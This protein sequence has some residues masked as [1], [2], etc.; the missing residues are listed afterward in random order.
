MS[1]IVLC[2]LLTHVA[3]ALQ[4]PDLPK[5]AP[6]CPEQKFPS[7]LLLFCQRKKLAL[8][9]GVCK[10]KSSGWEANHHLLLIRPELSIPH[11]R[12]CWRSQLPPARA[13]AFIKAPY[14]DT[15]LSLW[16]A[17]SSPSANTCKLQLTKEPEKGL[18]E[19]TL[20]QK[21]GGFR[22]LIS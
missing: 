21:T 5:L 17:D 12:K 20:L 1:K 3:S 13:L 22:G 6:P 7:T 11:W 18:K 2:H 10:E 4:S 8:T 19:T 15:E 14:V 16:F 9:R